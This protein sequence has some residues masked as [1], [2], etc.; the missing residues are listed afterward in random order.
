MSFWKRAKTAD[1]GG[2]SGDTGKAQ[3]AKKAVRRGA[4]VAFEVKLLAMEAL[5]TDLTP[6]EIGDIVGVSDSTIHAW[7]RQYQDGGSETLCRRP[8]SIAV[9]KT[10]ARLEQSIVA[11]RKQHPDH[12]VRR[13][14]DELLRADGLSVSAEKVRTTVDAAGLGNRPPAPRRRSRRSRRFERSLPN[15]MWQIDRTVG[16]C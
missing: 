1:L 10:C 11:H 6:Q 3:P 14:R 13:I 5:E 2:A 16:W 7:R 15:A 9:R 12:G 4:P 8:S